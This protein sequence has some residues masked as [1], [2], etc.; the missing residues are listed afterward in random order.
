[1]EGRWGRLKAKERERWKGKWSW[2][3]DVTTL[4]LRK[5]DS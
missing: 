5:F 3:E 4:V 1:M 2:G